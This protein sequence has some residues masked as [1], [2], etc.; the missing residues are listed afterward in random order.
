MC[1]EWEGERNRMI[2]E[3]YKFLSITKYSELDKWSATLS[4]IVFWE[5]SKYPT[6]KLSKILKRRKDVIVIKDES[7][8]KRIKIRQYGMGILLRDEVK[9]INIGTKRQFK[10][11][12]GQL[13]V[14]RIDARNGSF[15]IV[16]PELDGAIVTNDFW[17]FDVINANIDYL[18]ILL[19]AQAFQPIWQGKSNGTTNRQRVDE[20]DFLNVSIP[21]PT[22]SEQNVL[23]EE[24]KAS[25]N[26]S[27][28]LEKEADAFERSVD[29][30]L[31]KEL[32]IE[33]NL[34]TAGVN[35]KKILFTTMYS[36]IT[37]WGV[38][39]I[40]SILS[41]KFHKYK[42]TTLEE[43]P[44]L[45]INILRG[46]SP[47]YSDTSSIVI[48]N[49]KCNRWNEIDLQYAKGIDDIWFKGV[50]QDILTQLGDILINSTGE[51]TLGRT[52][53][54]N[55]ENLEGLLFDSHLLLLRPNRKY[56]DSLFFALLLNSKFGQ[57]QINM[58]KGAQATKQT[59][60]GIANVKKIVFPIPS[61]EEQIKI[62]AKIQK[63]QESIK[64]SRRKSKDVYE[65]A[66]KEFERG[67]FGEVN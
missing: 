58:L 22:I 18:Q 28:Q 25:I 46:K 47:R 2:K 52:S 49:Q 24:Y 1:R 14:S 36:D 67:V 13:I 54:V 57:Q 21:L 51:G 17:L 30:I 35:T 61:I 65:M 63:I 8:Y 15:G 20:Q 23:I 7:Y 50:K 39:K 19:S 5:Q 55:K 9:G 3:N 38:D 4:D 16:P 53:V 34:N 44:E 29:D 6:I 31:F 42:T 11:S 32:G 40:T 12:A 10:A 60:L 26:Y 66:R 59:E 64:V 37:Q 27:I 33:E 56:L 43:S 45:Y 41:Y 62:A 48:L